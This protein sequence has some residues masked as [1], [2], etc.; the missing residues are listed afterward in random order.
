MYTETKFRS[1]PD[2]DILWDFSAARYICKLIVLQLPTISETTHQLL[3]NFEKILKIEVKHRTVKLH[4]SISKG[5]QINDKQKQAVNARECKLTKFTHT[6][7][8]SL[9]T[10]RVNIF[11]QFL[12]D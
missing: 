3:G 12:Q 7:P 8:S 1:K 10:N 11:S 5:I 4:S 9:L 2:S 6:Q